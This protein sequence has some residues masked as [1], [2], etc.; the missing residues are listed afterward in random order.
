MNEDWMSSKPIKN[1][2]AYGF[3]VDTVTLEAHEMSLKE[4]LEELRREQNRLT[5]ELRLKGEQI[6]KLQIE[7]DLLMQIVLKK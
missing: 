4:S 5:E 6:K 2:S 7:R 1:P 3:R